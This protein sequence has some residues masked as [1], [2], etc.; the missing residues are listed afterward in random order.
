M[1]SFDAMVGF[2]VMLWICRDLLLWRKMVV[3][4]VFV[5]YGNQAEAEKFSLALAGHS[6]L[7]NSGRHVDHRINTVWMG[8]NAIKEIGIKIQGPVVEVD[9][10]ILV[11]TSVEICASVVPFLFSSWKRGEEHDRAD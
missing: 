7:L 1:L 11:E 10:T 4:G 5:G 2:L 8:L 3:G 6:P 9:K